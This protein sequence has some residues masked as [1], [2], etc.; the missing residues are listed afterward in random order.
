MTDTILAFL[1]RRM[2]AES[3]V[4]RAMTPD[5][6]TPRRT[7]YGPLER[8]LCDDLVLV[9]DWN[10]ILYLGKDEIADDWQ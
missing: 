3:R 8:S 6:T 9:P 10:R 1:R 2:A 5:T 7:P 4:P